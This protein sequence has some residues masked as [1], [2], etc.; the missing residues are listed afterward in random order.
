MKLF[1]AIVFAAVAASI[2]VAQP[3]NHVVISEVGP[4][5]GTNSQYD[6]GEFIELYNPFSVD[7]T[8]GP[9]V[10]VSS[11]SGSGS[12]QAD[13]TVSLSG[14]TIK[15]YGF[16]LIGDGGVTPAPDILFPAGK[17]LVNGSSARAHV[18]LVDGSTIIDAFGWDASVTPPDCEGTAFHP[19][20]N[21]SDYKSFQRKSGLT[22]VANDAL[23]DAWDSNNNANDFF[24]NTSANANP[25][26]SSSPVEINPYGLVPGSGA[27]SASIEP[28]RWYY[29]AST[30][31]T[32]IFKPA[33]DTVRS[34]KFVRP[35]QVSWT[36]DD[37]SIQPA[38]VNLT[39]SG[40]TAIL[41]NF[42]LQGDDSIVVAIPNV[43]AIDTTD[44]FTFHIQ[45][46]KDSIT[47]SPLQ[48]QPSTLVY[49]SPRPMSWVKAKAAGGT[50]LYTGKWVVVKGIVT[51]ADEF[52]GPSYLQDATAGISVYDSSVSNNVALGD[53][54]VLLG[55][56]SPYYNMFELQPCSLLQTLSHNNPIDTMLLSIPQINSQPQNGIEPYECRFI[57]VNDITSVLTLS[58]S[59]AATWAVS[60]SGTNYKLVSGADTVEVR[61][62][63]QT[64]LV[65]MAVP[66]GRFDIVGA[67]GQFV[68]Y[69]QIM[70]R[71]YNDII[72]SGE[73]PRITS[74]VPY[75]TNIMAS[76]LTFVW[77]TDVHGTS[78]VHYGTTAAY[79]DTLAD[80]DLVTEHQIT[81]T[82]LTPAT[83][84][85]VRLGSSIGGDT[86]YTVDYIV[87]T[88]SQS[89]SG[90]MNVYFNYPVDTTLER[91][92][93]AQTVNIASKL[94]ERI[95]AA[96]YSID[97]CLYSLSGTVGADVADALIA[98]KNSRDVK[99]RVIG[100]ADNSGT[101]PWGTLSSNSIPVIFDT[102]D[103]VNAGAGL[104]HN[105]F[106]IIDNR[107]T[108]SDTDDWVWTGSWNATDPG[109]ANDAQNAIEI[110]DK[111]LA[112]AYTAEF[113]EMWGSGTDTPNAAASRFG[114]HKL[115]N[116]PHYFVINGTPVEL[117]FSPSDGTNAQILKTFNNATHSVNFCI[118]SFTRNDLGN[119]LIAKYSSG[120]K[121]RGVLDNKTD[122]GEEYDTLAAS[123]CDVHLKVNVTRYL[124]HKYAII[125]AGEPGS[126]EY[127]ITG[128]HNWS[129]SAENSNNENTLI[130]NSRRIANL[131]LQEFSARYKDAGGTDILVGVEEKSSSMP[132]A[133]G[134]SQNYPNPFNPTT[135]IS[136]QLP[137]MSKVGL[138]VYDILGRKV[139]SLVDGI[140]S[141]GSYRI[142]WDA[143]KVSSGVYF[144][145]LQAG[146]YRA[147][148]KLLHLK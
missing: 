38:S 37:F 106:V 58:G 110:Q 102:Y 111:A 122:A 138:V 15:G 24:E 124:H 27:G 6:K 10:A 39:Q 71:S 104:M 112:N 75:E 65:N 12:N 128:S 33:G 139:A 85:H 16:Y 21:T 17:N 141:A 64:N 50:L 109:N 103:A 48:G 45:S 96:T 136:Y 87:S 49:G 145:R 73:G 67:L 126:E 81:L 84:Y 20:S 53:E 108:T 94:I 54:I 97:V 148:K 116:T 62:S 46:S 119:A 66:A 80:A 127:V 146:N 47:Y 31:L 2:S 61:I 117:Y 147:T 13:W 135:V 91:G 82:G 57:R 7:V 1:S 63:P 68:S 32:M 22:A 129:N 120:V 14:M 78:I 56:V 132:A 23:G 83:I 90:A 137:V 121:V 43:T 3:A 114:A 105:K 28:A 134:L 95:N 118:Y 36:P 93:K 34:F 99:M 107:D 74:G 79:T 142:T 89:S 5:G 19:S 125:D 144:Y 140:K 60:G 9:N 29:N 55:Q 133:Y 101:A 69:Y 25:Q 143:S 52:D 77:K 76:S 18:Q 131:Y 35:Q 123:G 59:P 130:I 44:E 70:P 30:I 26:N 41:S 92:E 42:V 8:F 100:E 88:A 115:N 113:N 51:V 98:A 72:P 11:G 4:M 86:T 40:D